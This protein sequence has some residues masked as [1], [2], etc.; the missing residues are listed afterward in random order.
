MKNIIEYLKQFHKDDNGDIVQTAIIMA[1]MSI[2][3]L[4]GYLF[5]KPKLT[6]LF[7]KTGSQLD[8][9]NNQNY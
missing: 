5:L 2:I 4:G 7:N 3:A 6:N 9:A 1:V 8:Q